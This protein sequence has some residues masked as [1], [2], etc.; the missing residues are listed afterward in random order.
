MQPKNK[1]LAKTRNGKLILE[2]LLVNTVPN[3]LPLLWLFWECQV[4]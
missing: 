3:L 4:C 1:G 2:K